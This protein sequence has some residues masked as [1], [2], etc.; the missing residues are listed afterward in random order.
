M[1]H[2]II[3]T[4]VSLTLNQIIDRLRAAYGTQGVNYSLLRSKFREFYLSLPARGIL[5]PAGCDTSSFTVNPLR[6]ASRLEAV[7]K[8]IK[9]NI[10]HLSRCS[11]NYRRR[12]DYRKDKRKL[13]LAEEILSLAEQIRKIKW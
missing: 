3:T 1:S 10:Y 13:Q 12:I 2:K 8:Q 6:F 11:Y 5:R 9:P 4:S 7:A